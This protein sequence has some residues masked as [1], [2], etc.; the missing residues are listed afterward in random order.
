MRVYGYFYDSKDQLNYG[1]HE[2]DEK[3]N[4]K[5]IERKGRLTFEPANNQEELLDAEAIKRFLIDTEEISNFIAIQNED[6]M[7]RYI[8]NLDDGVNPHK[9]YYYGKDLEEAFECQDRALDCLKY[10]SYQR[11]E[12]KEFAANFIYRYLELRENPDADIRALL[13]D[14]RS[15]QMVAIQYLE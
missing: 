3:L 10:I 4:T 2:V 7:L 13:R 5:L 9:I 11:Q 8:D 12:H 14:A 6:T 15:I 1:I